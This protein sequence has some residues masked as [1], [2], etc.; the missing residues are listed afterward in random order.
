MELKSSSMASWLGTSRLA[1][2][3][4]GAAGGSGAE[5]SISITLS[6]VHLDLS[7]EEL[8]KKIT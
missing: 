7:Q 3:G 6:L 5:R 4:A 1:G 8:E 2:A